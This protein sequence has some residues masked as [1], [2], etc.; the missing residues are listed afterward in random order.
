MMGPKGLRE[1]AEI[2]ALNNNYLMELVEKIRGIYP[3]VRRR[4][5]AARGV[6]LVLGGAH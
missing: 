3:P 5:P 4:P 6:P 2:S 1:T